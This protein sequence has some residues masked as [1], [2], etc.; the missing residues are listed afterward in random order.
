MRNPQ[1]S[2]EQ[3]LKASD[4]RLKTLGAYMEKV[5]AS[6]DTEICVNIIED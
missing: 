1:S 6:V 3:K 4:M 2:I 5:Q